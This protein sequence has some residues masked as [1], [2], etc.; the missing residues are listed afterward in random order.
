M[1]KL[2]ATQLYLSGASPWLPGYI[3]I[4]RGENVMHPG[5]YQPMF[6]MTCALYR[7]ATTTAPSLTNFN[8]HSQKQSVVFKI[9]VDQ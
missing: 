7:S 9:I 6:I 8:T 1:K 3:E 5:G 2:G 4:K